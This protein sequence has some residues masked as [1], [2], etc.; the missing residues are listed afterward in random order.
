[1]RRR[2]ENSGHVVIAEG[3]GEVGEGREGL[4]PEVGR[5]LSNPASHS[6]FR[7]PLLLW[8]EVVG[9]FPELGEDLVDDIF[10]L[11][12]PV[13]SHLRNIVN[14]DHRVDPVR[15]LRPVFEHISQ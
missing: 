9:D 8:V 5:T 11:V 15:L 3:G 6:P 12:Q 10:E 2:P 1:M 13:R 4:T 7:L 14:H